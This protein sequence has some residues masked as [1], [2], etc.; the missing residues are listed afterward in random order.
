M[1]G[2]D[3]EVYQELGIIAKE[4]FNLL[5][6]EERANQIDF[7]RNLKEGQHVTASSKINDINNFKGKI[8]KIDRQNHLIV[9]EDPEGFN[10]VLIILDYIIKIIPLIDIIINWFKSLFRK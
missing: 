10:R 6:Q 3:Q 4:K 8:K 7:I 9:I 1:K 5:T 2:I